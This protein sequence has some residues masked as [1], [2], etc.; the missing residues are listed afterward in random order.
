MPTAF[1]VFCTNTAAGTAGPAE[2]LERPNGDHMLNKSP[3]GSLASPP[4]G[5]SPSDAPLFNWRDHLPIHPAAELFPL[6]PE[7]ELKELAEDIKTN[8]LRA[9]IVGWASDEGQ[10]LLDGRNRL[11]ALAKL[12]LLYETEDHHVGIKTWEWVGKGW[13]DRRGGRIEAADSDVWKNCC[14]GDPYT[15]ALSLNV[16]RRHLT[17][18]QTRELIAKVLKATPEKSNRQIAKIVD[19]SHP[20]VAKVRDELEKAGDVERITTSLDTKGRRQPAKKPPRPSIL[21]AE[22]SAAAR[23]AQRAAEEA[24]LNNVEVPGKRKRVVV[25]EL[26]PATFADAPRPTQTS[27]LTVIGAETILAALP[28]DWLEAVRAW[29]VAHDA[30]PA[31]AAPVSSS[32]DG[33]DI[34]GSPRRDPPP[35]PTSPTPLPHYVPAHK[36]PWPKDWRHLDA[37]ALE[38]AIGAVQRFGVNHRLEERHHRQLARMRERLDDLRLEIPT[39]LLRG[40]PRLLN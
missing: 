1:S 27:F 35:A 16:H 20:T 25:I 13:S 3:H 7:A 33:L 23:K 26:N 24:E 12:S 21:D 17:P 9:P 29:V 6:M 38:E 32:D 14:D 15:I 37:V 5:A 10:F 8:G 39:S 40:P 4:N 28:L 36:D 34:P 22:A 30:R 31:P 11:D 2:D 19:R 18:E